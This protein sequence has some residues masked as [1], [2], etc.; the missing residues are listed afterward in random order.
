MAGGRSRE[1]RPNPSPGPGAGQGSGGSGAHRG[2]IWP[3]GAKPELAPQREGCGGCVASPVAGGQGTLGG[4]AERPLGFDPAGCGQVGGSGGQG[5]G[6][7]QAV[8]RAP[9]R[10][11]PQD[12][13]RASSTF[14]WRSRPLRGQRMEQHGPLRRR[15]GA[16]GT[17]GH[18]GFPARTSRLREASRIQ[19]PAAGERDARPQS[20]AL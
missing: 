3:C 18:P 11:R 6:A 15:L 2:G 19:G 5:S 1:L 16:A 17:E 20:H 7:G 13:L 14:R 12:R 8:P 9:P 10:Q 4:S